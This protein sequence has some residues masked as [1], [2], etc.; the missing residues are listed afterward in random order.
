M[1]TKNYKKLIYGLMLASAITVAPIMQPVAAHAATNISTVSKS[2]VVASAK[3]KQSSTKKKQ[4]STAK[5][6]NKMCNWIKK[7]GYEEDYHYGYIDGPVQIAYVDN[8]AS[9]AY[10]FEEYGIGNIGFDFTK[11][12]KYV[13]ISYNPGGD[14]NEIVLTAKMPKKKFGS[15]ATPDWELDE[16]SVIKGYKKSDVKK[17]SD[18][19]ND[20][21][22]QA[23]SEWNDALKKMGVSMK[24]LGF[25][26]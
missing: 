1:N 11:S 14:N 26:N 7:N 4:S 3:K 2:S 18:D 25:K 9:V 13:E 6:F 19:A 20:A 15:M 24:K 16:N 22:T 5:A 12:G 21:I 8:Y 10:Y 23:Y 17:F